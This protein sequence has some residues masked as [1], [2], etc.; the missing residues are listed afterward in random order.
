MQTRRIVV[1][2]GDLVIVLGERL[3]GMGANLSGADLRKAGLAKAVIRSGSGAATGR[4][5]SVDLTGA[6]LDGA[7]LDEE[8]PGDASD[9]NRDGSD[10]KGP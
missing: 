4:Y 8:E 7:I 1:D 3:R 5:R 6:R 10:T 9:A 2:D